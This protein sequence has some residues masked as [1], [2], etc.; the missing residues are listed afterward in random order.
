MDSTVKQKVC[1]T[2]STGLVGSEAV[3]FFA[4]K[5]WDVVGIDANKRAAFFD[6]PD[7]TPEFLVDIRDKYAVDAFFEDHGPFD[8][9]IHTAAQPSH[10]YSKDHVLEDFHTNAAGTLNLLEAARHLSPKAVFVQVSTDK[11]YGWGMRRQE[12]GP[13]AGQRDSDAWLKEGEDMY[14]SSVP[15][16]ENTPLE[17][18]FSPFGIS[19][20]AGDLYAREYAAQGWLTTGIFRPGCITGRNHEGAEQHGFLAYLAKCIKEGITYNINGYKGKQ[21][22][23]QIHAYDLVSAFAAFIGSPKS[24]AVYNIGGDYERAVSPLAAAKLI[25]EKTGKEFKYK[26]LDEP[27]FGDRQWDVHDMTKFRTDYPEWDYKYSL[28]DIITDLCS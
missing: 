20:L 2:G 5:G 3:E 23:D 21:V 17:P 9:I 28:D 12:Y 13:Y 24:G 26:Y 25:S 1:I 7:K 27:R 18:P 16:A 22:R 19:K 15:F 4:A 11:V 10:D 8:A 6:T 14:Y